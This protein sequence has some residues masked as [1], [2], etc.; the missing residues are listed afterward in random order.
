MYCKVT[1]RLLA[2]ESPDC[3]EQGVPL[4]RGMPRTIS[5]GKTSA[6]ESIP[7]EP[8][9][10]GKGEMVVQETTGRVCESSAVKVNSSRS[11]TK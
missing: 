9:G 10:S 1:V 8:Q 7:P 5:R 11:K 6:T 3:M 2:E 4:K